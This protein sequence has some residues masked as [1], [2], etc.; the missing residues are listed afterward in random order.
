MYCPRSILIKIYQKNVNSVEQIFQTPQ[1]YVGPNPQ[2]LT[3]I[4]HICSCSSQ[5][6]DMGGNGL[7]DFRCI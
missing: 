3:Y 4:F 1:N 5:G 7:A 2:F 6:Q